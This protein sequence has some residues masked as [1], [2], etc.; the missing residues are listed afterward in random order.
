[1]TGVNVQFVGSTVAPPAT[2]F[3]PYEVSDYELV[4]IVEGSATLFAVDEFFE[5]GPYSV[6]FSRP[7]EVN[8][9]H[10]DAEDP[11]RH[12]FVLFKLASDAR[13]PSPR[14]RHLERDDVIIALLN[15]VLW[16]QADQPQNW[17]D[18]ARDAVEFALRAFAT[19]A[20]QTN[21]PAEHQLPETI[22]QSVSILNERW[23]RGKPLTSPS[24][25]ELAEAA[26]VTP[27]HLCR[28]YKSELGMGPIGALRLV[29]L[30]RTAILLARSNM[31]VSDVAKRGGF[32][33][34]FH[35]SRAF[36]KVYGVSPTDFRR[37][38]RNF[39]A[40]P[41]QLERLKTYI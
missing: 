20:S 30:G 6:V 36:K 26:A 10:W 35:F 24:L 14:I 18:L 34:Q 13:V 31:S 27:E 41:P 19:G 25:N 22:V 32:S 23:A 15:H 21:R 9:Y 8:T 11:T 33:D 28:V 5:L 1:M 38:P 17:E 37:R 12:G 29:R 16:L 7:S 40:I 39:D 2:S 4:W 3:G